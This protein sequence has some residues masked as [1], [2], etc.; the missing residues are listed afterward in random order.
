VCSRCGNR[1]PDSAAPALARQAEALRSLRALMPTSLAQKITTQANKLLGERRDVTVVFV[2]IA[3]ADERTR[4]LDSEDVYLFVDEA[5]R[6]FGDVI[7]KYE[8]SIDRFTGDGLMALFG[9]PVTH[10]NEP[11]RGC[12]RCARGY[13]ASMG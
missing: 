3:S 8:G 10:E 13:S 7:Y 9:V 11:E 12:S 2:D 5:M 4:A 6:L 1:L